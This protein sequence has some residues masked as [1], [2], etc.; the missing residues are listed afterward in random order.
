[1]SQR[2]E[3][4]KFPGIVPFCIEFDKTPEDVTEE[5][6]NAKRTE[7][8]N[9][10]HGTLYPIKLNLNNLIKLYWR[11]KQI[12]FSI[13]VSNSYYV[14]TD[15]GGCE[16][17]ATETMSIQNNKAET[18]IEPS[19]PLNSLERRV[20]NNFDLYY[21]MRRLYQTSQGT[22]EENW[23]NTMGFFKDEF[24]GFEC[25]PII[26]EHTGGEYKP[27]NY[28]YYVRME[29]TFWL[30]SDTWATF[31]M[32]DSQFE[33]LQEEKTIQ[34]N[35]DGQNASNLSMYRISRLSNS[36]CKIERLAKNFSTWNID[37]WAT[38]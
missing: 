14:N 24:D 6:F 3:K 4:F 20:C 11:I 8:V 12:N 21:P 2:E 16:W 22:Y 34:V 18:T 1:M 31:M 25:P 23:E 37:L 13:N 26:A 33:G 15:L 29:F 35:I 30:Y 36:L 17:M 27:E 19:D 5:Y 9:T 38:P 32:F 28:L 7:N 10:Y